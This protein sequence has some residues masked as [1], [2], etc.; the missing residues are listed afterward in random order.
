[1]KDAVPINSGLLMLRD[2]ANLK[3]KMPISGTTGAF[4]FSGKNVTE[5]I[6]VMNIL[7]HKFFIETAQKKLKCLA[8]YSSE[9]VLSFYDTTSDFHDENYEKI[10]WKLK[11]HYAKEDKT[12]QTNNLHWLEQFINIHWKKN[13]VG[14]YLMTFH[15]MFNEIIKKEQLTDYLWAWMLLKD[16]SCKVC[17]AILNKE[18]VNSEN[19]DEME[20][21]QVYGFVKVR[22]LKALN[23]YKFHD[24]KVDKNVKSTEQDSEKEVARQ[25]SVFI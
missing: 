1:M 17:N 21:E 16:L 7:F 2:Q 12:Q 18:N 19:S 15:C 9:A 23:K 14:E 24:E 20:Y 3:S 13:E 22:K 6:R 4:C 25:C 11:K 5:F 8:D 10:C